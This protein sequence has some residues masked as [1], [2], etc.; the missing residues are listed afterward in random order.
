AHE[1][2]EISNS[3][4]DFETKKVETLEKVEL[5]SEEEKPVNLLNQEEHQ[6]PEG[7]FNPETGFGWESYLLTRLDSEINRAIA[8]EID[9]SLFIIQL[10]SLPR[11][12]ELVKHVCNYL[13]IQFQFKDLLFELN[14]DCLV[15]MKISMDID[16]ALNL[17]DKIYADIKNIIQNN[18]CFI[19]ISS[20]SIR[21]VSGER[22]LHEAQEALLHAKDDK[23]SPIIAFRVDAEKYRQFLEQNQ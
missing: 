19:G 6:N 5:P 18:E 10:P 20:R 21:M 11:T 23:D 4:G 13:S 3:T 22:L 2:E 8:S 12:S 16:E 9:L 7:L 14:D 15:A 1:I 17:S